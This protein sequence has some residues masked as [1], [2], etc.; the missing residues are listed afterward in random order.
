MKSKAFR[1]DLNS[2]RLKTYSPSWG[3]LISTGVSCCYKIDMI[4]LFF[5]STHNKKTK[6]TKDDPNTM[7]TSCITHTHDIM[8]T[9]EDNTQKTWTNTH[10]YWSRRPIRR[11]TPIS[12]DRQVPDQRRYERKSCKGTLTLTQ[13]PRTPRN[14][15]SDTVTAETIMNP[16]TRDPRCS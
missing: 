15:Q 16:H 7:H 11:S 5:L 12:D 3:S 8:N 13:K 6:N 4:N 2:I 14:K 1:I 9:Y 10:E